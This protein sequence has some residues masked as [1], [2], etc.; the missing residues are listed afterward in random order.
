[1]PIWMNLMRGVFVPT[2][3]DTIMCFDFI[4]IERMPAS[5]SHLYNSPFFLGPEDQ[6]HQ[7][8]QQLS[9]KR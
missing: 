2:L 3:A 9:H 4:V 7:R 1:M 8:D 6:H 5:G